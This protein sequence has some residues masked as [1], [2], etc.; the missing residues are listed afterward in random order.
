KRALV[1]ALHNLA[2]VELVQGN[3]GKG[4]TLLRESLDISRKLKH[5]EGI[6]MGL[7]GFA[8]VAI[9]KGQ[10]DRAARLLGAT[11]VLLG[12]LGLRLDHPDQIEYNGCVEAART[13]LGDTAFATSRAE[14]RAM[15]L[16]Q[17][18]E[19]ALSVEAD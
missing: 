17:A 11:D 1:A 9:A 10:Q 15:T 7:V 6:A 14:G 13:A 12:T 2:A 5:R 4:E 19:Y 8:G 18:V 3:H 16:E